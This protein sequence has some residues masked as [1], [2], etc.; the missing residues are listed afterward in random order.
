MT[1]TKIHQGVIDIKLVF[2]ATAIDEL[3]RRD[4]SQRREGFSTQPGACG[5]CRTGQLG[6]KMRNEERRNIRRKRKTVGQEGP[7]TQLYTVL[8]SVTDGLE[9]LPPWESLM[10]SQC[11]LL[12]GGREWYAKM[13]EGGLGGDPPCSHGC[14]ELGFN[15]Y[16]ELSWRNND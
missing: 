9:N 3:P 14:T 10:A 12:S 11:S 6:G 8:L 15:M 13:A 4:C 7:S 5:H 1:G 16:M 2:K